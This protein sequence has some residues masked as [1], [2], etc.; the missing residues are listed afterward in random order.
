MQTF[1]GDIT[2][3]DPNRPF[4][5]DD[6]MPV[7][8]YM[9]IAPND[10]KT[11]ELGRPIYDDVEFIKIFNS[12]DNIIDRPVR[13]TDRQ[14]W[15]RQYQAWKNTG[16][17]VPGGSGTMLEAWPQISRAVAEEM[18]YFKIF[19]VEQLAEF[20]DS[21]G[22]A[23]MGFQRLKALAKGYLAAAASEAPMS[24]MQAELEERDGKIAFLNDQLAKMQKKLEKLMAKAGVE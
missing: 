5:A 24:K 23:I 2:N 1:D 22:Q 14:R 15:P 3:F 13:D 8:F 12:K 9:G 18:K 21:T 16:A 17:N 20:P 11:A 19:T 10:A 4:I 7:Q 6:K